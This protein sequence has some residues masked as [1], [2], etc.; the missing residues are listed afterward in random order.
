[1]SFGMNESIEC[2]RIPPTTRQCQAR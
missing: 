1:V 2:G